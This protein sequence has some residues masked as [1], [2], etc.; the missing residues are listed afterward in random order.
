MAT[1]SST[2]KMAAK[3]WNSVIPAAFIVDD[4]ERRAAFPEATVTDATRPT[5]CLA[6]LVD[7]MP[8][9]ADFLQADDKAPSALL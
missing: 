8:R 9:D 2:S 6:A 7:L 4:T 3:M 1:T 5:D